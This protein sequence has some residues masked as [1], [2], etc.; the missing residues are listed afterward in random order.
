M[1]LPRLPLLLALAS[2]I[3]ASPSLAQTQSCQWSALRNAAD[4]YIESQT[5]GS[6]DPTL[7]PPGPPSTNSS[8]PSGS[9]SPT[10]PYRQNDLPIP[11]G[12]GSLPGLLGT[13]P[14]N[15][16]YYH[17]R[18]DQSGC[19]T[20]S[21]LI[22]T[23]PA[24]PYVIGTQISYAPS[25][26]GGSTLDIKLVDSAVS[27]PRSIAFDASFRA[28]H[29]DAHPWGAVSRTAQDSR[30]TLRGVADAYLDL[31]SGRVPADVPW[32]AD[33]DRLLGEPCLSMGAARRG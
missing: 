21:E 18:I 27:T 23:D 29:L 2:L 14:L 11:S 5:S 16:T 26:R 10:I 9:S 12:P 31:W 19:A 17:T 25:P 6:L 13:T 1:P 28:A 4:T 20:Y 22:V 7:F 33:C 30:A 32:G 3:P 8:S 24:N 15:I